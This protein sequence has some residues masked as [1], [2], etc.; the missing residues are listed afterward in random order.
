[1]NKLFLILAA[2]LIA[3]CAGGTP[4]DNAENTPRRFG[5]D[6]YGVVCYTTYTGHPVGCVQVQEGK[7]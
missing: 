6:E 4:M 2:C 3:G 5:P 1:M 7:D